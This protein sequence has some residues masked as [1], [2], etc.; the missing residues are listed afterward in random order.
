MS[1]LRRLYTAEAVEI[2]RAEPGENT[3][4]T[5]YTLRHRDGRISTR[6]SYGS[7]RVDDLT[8]SDVAVLVWGQQDG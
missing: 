7:G 6:R 5:V 8:G 1:E 4:D 2:L 3:G